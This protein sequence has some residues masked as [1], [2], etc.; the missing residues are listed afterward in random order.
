MK[1]LGVISMTKE[2]LHMADQQKRGSKEYSKPQLIEYGKVEDLT[3]G[4][5]GSQPDSPLKQVVK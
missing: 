2:A 4:G 3:K 5:A 1:G